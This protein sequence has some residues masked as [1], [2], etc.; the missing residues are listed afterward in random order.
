[1][2]NIFMQQS[3][4]NKRYLLL[5]YFVVGLG[6]TAGISIIAVLLP[7]QRP[8]FTVYIIAALVCM[9]VIAAVQGVMHLIM[10]RNYETAL[11]IVSGYI[12]IMYL[13]ILDAVTRLHFNTTFS[14]VFIIALVT[15]QML[16]FYFQVAFDQRGMRFGSWIITIYF[17]V[18]LAAIDVILAQH[19]SNF[20]LA[21]EVMKIF[22]VLIV[23]IFIV[24]LYSELLAS[25][26]KQNDENRMLNDKL[27]GAMK[28]IVS[29][30]IFSVM[31]HDLKNMMHTIVMSLEGMRMHAA[32]PERSE[33]YFSIINRSVEDIQTIVN[34]FLTYIRLDPQRE[35]PV[36]IRTVVS[37]ALDFVR[38]S[39]SKTVQLQFEC[40]GKEG[41]PLIVTASKYRILSVF[42]NLIT[43]A[44]QSHGTSTAVDKKIAVSITRDG[45][46]AQVTVWDNGPGIQPENLEKIF[47]V[48][49]TKKEGL[50][51]GLHFVYSYITET[52]GGA[53]AVESIPEKHTV[54]TVRLPLELKR[55]A[56]RG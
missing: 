33:K 12:D 51:L 26:R 11:I 4:L 34:Q 2:D 16:Y 22:V 3:Q 44:V 21:Y 36:D 38:I 1:M 39:R 5:R 13:L 23:Q 40:T 50:G 27:I 47:T 53:I 6:S 28:F 45:G 46:D 32:K 15:L 14:P 48:F 20:N 9:G 41:E 10:R 25:I 7:A 8:I 24:R 55:G 43:N 54:F 29:G 56:I 49:T 17:L 35:E 19:Y 30:E 31:L 42:L 18:V 37:E 52:L